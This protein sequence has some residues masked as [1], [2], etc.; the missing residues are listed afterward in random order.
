MKNRAAYK[1]TIAR[2]A[3]VNQKRVFKL[4][5]KQYKESLSIEKKRGSG[6][7]KEF[8]EQN[9][10]SKIMRIFPK[11]PYLTCLEEKFLK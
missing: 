4:I 6:R 3:S 1:T 8:V 7:K 2:L 5:L 10:A 11:T 9:K